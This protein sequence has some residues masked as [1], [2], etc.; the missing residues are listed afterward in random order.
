MHGPETMT[1]EAESTRRLARIVGPTLIAVG[2]AILVRRGELTS[3]LDSFA[4]DAAIGMLA[5]IVG[6]VA[7]LVLLAYHSRISTL[8]ALAMTLLGWAML[9]RGLGL[10]FAPSWVMVAARWFIET[11]HAFD[12]TGALVALFGA[13]LSTV[14]FSA[15]PLPLSS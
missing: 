11:P 13:W 14:G 12:V 3:I 9:A 10:M 15:R 4:Q 7:G 2:L 5:G 6:F 8:A 1:G